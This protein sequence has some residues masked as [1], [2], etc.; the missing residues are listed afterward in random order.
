M[1]EE[2][3]YQ[4]GY[5]T[6]H[7]EVTDKTSRLRKA[8]TA[9]T[10]IEEHLGRGLAGLAALD[11]GGSSGVMAEY[12][13]A[14][15]CS[16]VAIDI[17]EQAIAA[18]QARPAIANVEFRLGDAMALAFADASFD[19]VLCCHVYEHVPDPE[20][21]MR[22]I[23]RVLRPGGV[24]YF[25]AGNRLAWREPHYGLPLLSVIPRTWAHRYLRLMGRGRFYHEKH[26]G[27][28]GLKRLVE[29]FER[30]D[31]TRDMIN[32]PK[33]YG[34]EYQLAPN[35]FAQ[36]TARFIINFLPWACPGYIWILRKIAAA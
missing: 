33:R 6:L 30:H 23:K 28:R 31:A 18:A 17:D 4:H 13:A 19:I 32:D 14:N 16:V 34:I 8:R 3:S 12:F 10:V 1:S 21:M 11:V 29:D 36:L 2:R 15:G 5:S 7:P 22:E 35:S 20:R 24:C 27:F 26:L 25:A 9:Q